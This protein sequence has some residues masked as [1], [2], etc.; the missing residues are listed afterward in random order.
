MNHGC[1]G[2]YNFGDISSGNY[3]VQQAGGKKQ[4]ISEVT[5]DPKTPPKENNVIYEPISYRRVEQSIS[6][7]EGSLRDIAK[8]EEMFT[9]Y[10]FMDTTPSGWAANVR[11]LRAQ[12]EG[13]EVG[14]VVNMERHSLKRRSSAE[15]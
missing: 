14:L 12:C 6:S 15:D 2:T 10:I 4:F 13:T 9:T 8:G 7:W 5:V 3:Y 11:E 1:N